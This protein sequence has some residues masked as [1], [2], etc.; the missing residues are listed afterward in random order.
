MLDARTISVLGTVLFGGISCV[1]IRGISAS[2]A[3]RPSMVGSRSTELIGIRWCAA[4][5]LSPSL[6]TMRSCG[7]STFDCYCRGAAPDSPSLQRPELHARRRKE[8]NRWSSAQVTGN[9][10]TEDEWRRE[11]RDRSGAEAPPREV[12]E[13]SKP[14]RREGMA[15]TSSRSVNPAP[16][17]KV[18]YRPSTDTAAPSTR[19]RRAPPRRPRRRSV[20][21]PAPR[22][23]Y[24]P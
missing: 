4:A 14:V 16:A 9:A 15:T 20:P 7:M 8:S 2:A 12:N 6:A 24:G 19:P 5:S 3:S 21:T 13:A 23:A 18:P 10:S 11:G 22:V 1:S 17:H